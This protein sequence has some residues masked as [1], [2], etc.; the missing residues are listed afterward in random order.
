MFW[1]SHEA[2]EA[3]VEGLSELA[4]DE[5]EDQEVRKQAVF[6]L[7]QLDGDRGVPVL[8][9]VATTDRDPVIRK[10][11]IFWLGQSDDPRALDLFERLLTGKA[12]KR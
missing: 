10:Q 6:A 4:A 5:A 2:G 12:P 11:A 1:L 8:I 7:S 9:R 3:A